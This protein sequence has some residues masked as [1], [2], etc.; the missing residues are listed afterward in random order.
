MKSLKTSPELVNHVV[1]IQ[2]GS[3]YL[4]IKEENISTIQVNIEGNI[5]VLLAEIPASIDVEI[6]FQ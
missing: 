1:T 3:S 6:C 2:N 5:K 4:M